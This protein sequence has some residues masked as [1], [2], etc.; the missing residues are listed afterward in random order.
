[1][2]CYYHV[3][4]SKVANRNYRCLWSCPIAVDDIG[5]AR[6]PILETI[7]ITINI[8]LTIAKKLQ[9]YK[10]LMLINKDN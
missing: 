8:K 2:L 7:M 9:T 1:M 6:D 4:H 3:K 10:Q 5:S